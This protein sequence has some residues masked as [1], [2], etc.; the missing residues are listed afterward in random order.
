MKKILI[1]LLVI[2]LSGCNNNVK[3]KGK[4]IKE[5]KKEIKY[6]D[7]V[8][9]KVGEEIPSIKD[10][11]DSE[12][13]DKIVWNNIEL[14]DNKIYHVGIYDGKIN[15][16]NIKLEV[17]DDIKP[18]IEVSD[19][20]INVG[21]NINLLDKVKVTDNS[22]DEI[23]IKLSDYN[24]NKAGTYNIDVTATDKGNNT[25]TKSFKLIVKEKEI[26]KVEKQE[27][28]EVKD[29]PNVPDVDLSGTTSKG[30]QVT[31]VDG[32]YYINGILIAN[33]TYK[34]PSTYNPGGLTKAFTTAFNEMKEAAAKDG[35]SLWVAS[36]F[37]S[38]SYQEKL[39]N[40][41]VKNYGKN[42]ADTFSARAG[43]S[44]HQTGLAA[45]LNQINEA[46]ENTKAGIWLSN[47]CY[48]YGFILRYP[49]GKQNITGY[50]YEPWH[51]RYIKDVK[52]AEELYNNNEWL[53]LEEYFGID[54][55]YSN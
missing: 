10:Y 13:T 5:E 38:Y 24:I 26:P 39:Y 3:D 31:R 25:S 18:T 41:Y 1:I 37:R 45:D 51:F 4:E 54:S 53:S 52:I 23:D 22:K 29:I 7:K 43:H 20:T 15:D 14:D 34:L 30:Y 6:K 33:K 36:G 35:V 21:D 40:G 11:T 12:T 55:K 19:I 32:V 2:L 9:I 46:F 8:T 16:V 17:I 47:N 28:K 50:I 27:E 49:K 44:E 48:K 42:S